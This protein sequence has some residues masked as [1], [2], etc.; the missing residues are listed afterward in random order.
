[1]SR[2]GGKLPPPPH[3]PWRVKPTSKIKQAINQNNV[4][5]KA[6]E[7]KLAVQW[8]IDNNYR[9]WSAVKSENFLLLK[10]KGLLINC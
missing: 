3:Y 8:C 2:A 1:M 7:M 10:M 6:E 5:K 9:G 4:K